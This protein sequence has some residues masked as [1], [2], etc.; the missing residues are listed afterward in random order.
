MNQVINT[1]DKCRLNLT[2]NA[3]CI[4]CERAVKEYER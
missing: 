3:V 1:G 4:I 2:H